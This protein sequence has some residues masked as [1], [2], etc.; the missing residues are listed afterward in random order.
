MR[1]YLIRNYFYLALVYRW[2][3]SAYRQVHFYMFL[4]ERK[5]NFHVRNRKYFNL[6][7]QK[8]EERYGKQIYG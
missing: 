3:P 7:V 1:Y 5:E 6:R 4:A 2:V 8:K